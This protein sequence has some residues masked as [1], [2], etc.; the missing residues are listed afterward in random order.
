[1]KNRTTNITI[2]KRTTGLILFPDGDEEDEFGSLWKIELPPNEGGY[3]GNRGR[4]YVKHI[5]VLW[6]N[7]TKWTNNLKNTFEKTS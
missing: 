1:M 5:P 6:L 7:F 2:M 4:E 3:E